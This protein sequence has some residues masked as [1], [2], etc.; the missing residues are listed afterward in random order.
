MNKHNQKSGFAGLEILLVLVVIGLISALGWFVYKQRSQTSSSTPETTQS[1]TPNSTSSESKSVISEQTFSNE[2]YGISFHYP[3]T[4]TVKDE[5]ATYIGSGED[6]PWYSQSD[7]VK[8][9]LSLDGDTV[10]ARLV[11]NNDDLQTIIGCMGG[12]GKVDKTYT[13]N[14]MKAYRVVNYGQMQDSK[15]TEYIVVGPK[16]TFVVLSQD[17]NQ[18]SNVE[19]LLGTLKLT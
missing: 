8:L 12:S 5:T 6:F 9:L 13:L 1:S 2:Q 11:M 10:T 7:F 18:N 14:G 15:D 4:F 3:E 19:K 17:S 16:Y